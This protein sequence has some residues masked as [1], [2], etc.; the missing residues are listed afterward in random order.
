[1]GQSS[2]P[3]CLSVCQIS[4]QNT[5]PTSLP[6]GLLQ[7][8]AERGTAP[9]Y[10]DVVAARHDTLKAAASRRQAGDLRWRPHAASAQHWDA[11]E[12]ALAAQAAAN[13][14]GSGTNNGLI[15]RGVSAPGGLRGSATDGWLMRLRPA[16]RTTGDAPAAPAAP[17]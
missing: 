6:P 13:R 3:A 11:A 7:F 8:R 10:A 1:M 2:L 12:A 17:L 16:R 14:L 15:G 4:Q 5:H 9:T